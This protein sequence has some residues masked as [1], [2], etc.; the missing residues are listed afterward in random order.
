MDNAINRGDYE[1]ADVLRRHPAVRDASV[2]GFP[3]QRLDKI[4]VGAVELV[5]GS[6]EPRLDEPR[7]FARKYLLSYQFPARIICLSE[8]PRNASLKVMAPEVRALLE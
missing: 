7:A 6:L 1:V 4:P 3:D 8:L 2:V 5:K